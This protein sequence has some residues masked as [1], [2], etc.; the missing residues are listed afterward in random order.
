MKVVIKVVTYYYN[1]LRNAFYLT[2]AD[3]GIM[4][5]VFV[6]GDCLS[7][8]CSCS[9]L[10][11]S[12]NSPG[13]ISASKSLP[14]KA[15]LCIL[16]RSVLRL[17]SKLSHEDDGVVPM[18]LKSSFKIASSSSSSSI[19]SSSFSCPCGSTWTSDAGFSVESVETNRTRR[20]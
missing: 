14:D 3:G 4:R 15:K 10:E 2:H 18:L 13:R 1:S 7:S 16:R 17:R 5:L 11:S 20:N 8:C 9:S 12:S 6:S 19:M